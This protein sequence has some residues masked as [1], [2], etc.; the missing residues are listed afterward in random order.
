[1]NINF[2]LSTL[3][4]MNGLDEL[5]KSRNR[6]QTENPMIGPIDIWMKNLIVI[7]NF[8]LPLIFIAGY[9][10]L[11]FINRNRLNQKVYTPLTGA[12]K[13]GDLHG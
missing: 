13:A 7:F 4:V 3:D 10:I 1:M 2:F 11:R 8:M 9:A 6:N 12:A 5:V